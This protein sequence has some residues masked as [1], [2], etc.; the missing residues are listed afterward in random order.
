MTVLPECLEPGRDAPLGAHAGEGGINFAVFSQRAETVELCLYA[1]NGSTELKRYWLHGPDDGIFHG[2]LG[3]VSS[4]LCYGYRVHGDYRPENGRRFNA[5]KL[6]LDPYAHAI[7]GQFNW[8]DEH[9][10]YLH[11]HPG[12]DRLPNTCDNGANALKGC[13]L[14]DPGAAPGAT[15]R[16]RHAASDVVLYELHVKGFTMQLPGIPENLR[17]SFA[18]LAHPLAIAHFKKLGVTTL[19]LLPVQYALNERH[20]AEKGLVNYWGYNPI[21]FFCP[22][23]R[24]CAA[25]TPETQREEFRQM[26]QILH[27]HGLEVVI[28]VVFNHTAEGGAD[29]PTLSFRGLDNASWYMLV[30]DD[31]SRYEN[32]SGCG[33][34]LRVAH[35]RVAQFVMDVLRYWVEVMGVDGFRFD[36][37]P[38]LGRTRQGFETSAAFFTAL[39]QDPVLA[40]VH[41]IAEPWDTGPGGYQLGR[42]PGKFLEWNDRF[43]DA[44]RGYWLGIG[45]SRGEFARRVTG[46]SDV[47]HHGGRQPVASVNFVAAHD[48]FTLNDAVSY[49][50]KRNQANGESNRDGHAHE[51]SAN[52]GVEGDT[53]VASVLETR[54]RVRRAL[55]A[56]VMVAQGTPMLCAGDEFGNSQLGNNNAYCQDNPTGWLDWSAG[57]QDPG[58]ALLVAK[59]AALRRINPLL[60]HTRWFADEGDTGNSPQL[61]W[62]NAAGER[63]QL[64][65]W[66]D[67]SD[68]VF[69]CQVQDGAEAV[70]DS[71]VVFNPQNADR[72][73]HLAHGPWRIV[74][75]TTIPEAPASHKPIYHVT[76]PAHSLL[77]LAR[78]PSIQEFHP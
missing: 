76:V 3:G 52:F 43:R 49:T 53:K 45:V 73:V 25:E 64:H 65:D 9:H 24:L 38:V 5:N 36:L 69:A 67:R 22:D 60:R 26:V 32:H 7:V 23:P 14:P 51:I 27:S 37:A 74:L 29:G 58:T 41:W 78:A 20:L 13:I 16:P 34:T 57:E 28:D 48:G 33:N 56:T 75:D 8:Q 55:L 54:I 61:H 2:F 39:R 12:G 42:F 19:S 15:N 47:F 68:S 71:C 6:L 17:G 35:P 59:L 77:I 46:S 11:D 63:M 70:P 10:G 40:G 62:Y 21:G 31:R 50:Q 30:P 18:A 1:D 44:V 66:H 72:A 4:R